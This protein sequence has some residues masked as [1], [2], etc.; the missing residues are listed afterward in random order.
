MKDSYELLCSLSK[1]RRERLWVSVMKLKNSYEWAKPPR[2]E[3][4]KARVKAE[5]AFKVLR[6]TRIKRVIQTPE[7]VY[8]WN[9]AVGY[10]PYIS[11]GKCVIGAMEC[12]LGYMTQDIL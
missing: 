8:Y 11:G 12:A 6:R 5:R 4:H 1:S 10:Y 7:I 9:E 2:K 3:Q